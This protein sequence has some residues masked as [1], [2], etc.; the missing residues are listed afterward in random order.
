MLSIEE[1]KQLKKRVRGWGKDTVVQLG[2]SLERLNLRERIRP[3]GQTPLRESLKFSMRTSQGDLSSVSFSYVIHGLYLEVGAGKNRPKGSPAAARAAKPWLAPVIP[4]AVDDLA[5]ILEQ[6]FANLA[7][8]E[9]KI[10]IP[11]VMS[12]KIKQ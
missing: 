6:E 5:D 10:N 4:Q 7:T 12:T 11:G 1:Q 9:I 3:A 8:E 2:F